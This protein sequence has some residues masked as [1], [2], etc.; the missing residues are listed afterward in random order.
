MLDT[1]QLSLVD[2]PGCLN[3]SYSHPS[4]VA[5]LNE[6]SYRYTK[7]HLPVGKGSNETAR[8][9]DL[10]EPSMSD[11]AWN[12]LKSNKVAL[13]YNTRLSFTRETIVIICHLVTPPF[14]SMYF[15]ISC[16]NSCCTTIEAKM[17]KKAPNESKLIYTIGIFI[18]DFSCL[19]ISY[20]SHLNT[21]T[22]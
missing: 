4:R 9:A 10:F 14:K 8:C 22:N 21:Q 16:K 12:K 20:G 19:F 18:V 3:L 6:S 1:S 5:I 17:M 7:S 2:Q 13:M 11:R 15:Q